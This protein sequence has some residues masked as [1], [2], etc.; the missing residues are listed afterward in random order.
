ME[1]LTFKVLTKNIERAN[2]ARSAPSQYANLLI[3]LSLA[4]LTH[5]CKWSQSHYTRTASLL[6]S[7]FE[8][9]CLIN[10]LYSLFSH[11]NW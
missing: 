8:T 10:Y 9:I 7:E 2:R 3:F 6:F 5:L 4:S 11:T 1:D